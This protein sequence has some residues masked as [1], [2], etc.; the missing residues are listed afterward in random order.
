MHF[1]AGWLD[2]VADVTGRID[3]GNS[4]SERER[5]GSGWWSRL[6]SWVLVA[7]V[8]LVGLASTALVP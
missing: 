6:S 3:C 1:A 7:R 2:S 8:L 4:E 5:D